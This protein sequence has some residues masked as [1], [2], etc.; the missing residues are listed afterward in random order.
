MPLHGS[1]YMSLNEIEA[2]FKL[3]DTEI[4]YRQR[5]I[6]DLEEESDYNPQSDLYKIKML[7]KTQEKLKKKINK[8]RVPYSFIE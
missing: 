3:V 8:I 2:I 6:K 1:I 4:D 5:L 7:K